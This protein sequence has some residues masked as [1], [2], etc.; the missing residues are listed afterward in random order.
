MDLKNLRA[1]TTLRQGQSYWMA[2]LNTGRELC[3]LDTLTDIKQARERHVEWLEDLIATG[4]IARVVSVSLCTPMGQYE[5]SVQEP[6]T[7]FQFSQGMLSLEGKRKTAQVIGVMNDAATGHCNYV[8][9][10]VALQKVFIGSTSVYHFQSW[11]E[12]LPDLGRLNIEALDLRGA[13]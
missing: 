5:I 11:R 3:E 9:W 1:M 12:G 13:L 6:H 4:D 7:A 10:D 2:K 8:V